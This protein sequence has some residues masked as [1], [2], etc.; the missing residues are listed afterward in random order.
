MTLK[1]QF[2]KEQKEKSTS[3]LDLLF[4]LNNSYYIEWLENKI[5]K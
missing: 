5:N 1:E 4:L 2:E 3:N